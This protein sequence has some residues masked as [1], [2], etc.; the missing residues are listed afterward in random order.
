MCQKHRLRLFYGCESCQ[1]EMP[2]V[3]FTEYLCKHVDGTG[4]WKIVNENH[5]CPEGYTLDPVK[6]YAQ[7]KPPAHEGMPRI[8]PQCEDPILQQLRQTPIS[9]Q[10]R[11]E[12]DS[13]V[14]ARIAAEDSIAAPALGIDFGTS[15]FLNTASPRRHLYQRLRNEHGEA[16]ARH[17]W[18][19]PTPDNSAG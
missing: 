2:A 15:A 13:R 6:A 9:P 14:L 4:T 11:R 17:W 3:E 1:M 18:L 5:H 10:S 19:N 7:K 16:F 8:C 12:L